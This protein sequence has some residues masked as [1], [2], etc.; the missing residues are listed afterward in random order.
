[1]SVHTNSFLVLRGQVPDP[2]RGGQLPPLREA[3]GEPGDEPRA[4]V[5]PHQRHAA[6][7][8]GT[9][10]LVCRLAHNTPL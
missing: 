8:G 4:R 2:L 3:P 5:V 7:R 1:M 6:A 9:D 10:W